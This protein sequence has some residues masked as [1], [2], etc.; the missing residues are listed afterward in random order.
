MIYGPFS[1]ADAT[2][3]ELRFKAWVNTEEPAT[4][5]D[6][7][8][9][10]AS[11]DGNVFHGDCIYGNSSGWIDQVLD[12]SN[13][14]DLGDLAGQSNVWVAL[15]FRSDKAGSYSEGVYV[16]DIILRKCTGGDCSGSS[17]ELPDTGKANLNTYPAVKT[18][19]LP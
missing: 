14:P 1:L 18:L 15:W 3:A 8:C 11:T 17:P 7:L 2:D 9:R 5:Y 10:F 6:Y 16:D 4:M 12:L 19:E 13:V